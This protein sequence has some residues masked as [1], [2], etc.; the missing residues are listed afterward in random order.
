MHENQNNQCE[1]CYSL[2]NLHQIVPVFYTISPDP[3]TGD[4]NELLPHQQRKYIL[5]NLRRALLAIDKTVH[6]EGISV[7][8]E[9]NKAGNVHVHGIININDMYAGC[10]L[11]LAIIKKAIHKLMGRKFLNSSISCNLDYAADIEYCANYV[12]K[13]NV[14]PSLHEIYNPKKSIVDW[15]SNK[16]T[17]PIYT[18][19]PHARARGVAD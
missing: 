8:F 9:L 13:E 1:D 18:A 14:Y 11:P 4:F 6:I 5:S 12:N 2:A 19:R 7:H 15:F 16:T 10:Q 3:E 17:I